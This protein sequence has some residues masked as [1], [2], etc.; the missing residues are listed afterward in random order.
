M[1]MEHRHFAKEIAMTQR[2][3]NHFPAISVRNRDVNAPTFDEIHGIT[4]VADPE[5][6]RDAL[7]LDGMQVAAKFFYCGIIERREKR[8]TAQKS[9][10]TGLRPLFFNKRLGGRRHSNYEVGSG[11]T[12]GFQ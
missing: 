3:E 5:Q 6:T 12:F 1:A 7:E 9:I 2:S 10:L 4:G 11:D 8:D